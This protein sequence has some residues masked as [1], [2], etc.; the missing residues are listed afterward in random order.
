MII[1]CLSAHPHSTS[2]CSLPASA[3]ETPVSGSG[4]HEGGGVFVMSSG[5][6]VGA[7]GPWKTGEQTDDTKEWVGNW[8]SCSR[9]I[10]G[11]LWVWPRS[12]LLNH[13]I[14][15]VAPSRPVPM[16]PALH[17][18][19]PVQPSHLHHTNRLWRPHRT[20]LM[21]EPRSRSLRDGALPKPPP[22]LS[23]YQ[24]SSPQHILPTEMLA[25]SPSVSAMRR[26]RGVGTSFL[27]PVSLAPNKSLIS[28]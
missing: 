16:L 21:P 13:I 1:T 15:I 10:F 9:M 18:L 22:R 19:P 25:S 5:G 26:Q 24:S 23:S 28:L 7:R 6:Q 11:E 3:L 27:S 14:N 2:D 20:K 8:R 12:P 4:L 17:P